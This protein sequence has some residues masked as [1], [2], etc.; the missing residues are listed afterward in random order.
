VVAAERVLDNVERDVGRSVSRRDSGTEFKSF[1]K[2]SQNS[3]FNLTEF[4]KL[5]FLT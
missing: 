2:L 5:F 3:R 1:K 4:K